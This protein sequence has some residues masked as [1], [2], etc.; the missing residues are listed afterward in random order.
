SS[1][2]APY[3]SRY[4]SNSHTI[5]RSTAVV[6]GVV[7]AR[8]F[9]QG[10][11]IMIGS[12][13]FTTNTP[14]DRVIANAMLW[15]QQAAPGPVAM[16][17]TISGSFTNGVWAGP[18]TIHDLQTNI[19]MRASIASAEGFSNP[20]NTAV[21]NDLVL[22]VSN[23]PDPVGVGF[24]VNYTV[25]A[26]NTGPDESTQVIITNLL[27]PGAVF[28]SAIL[29]QGSFTNNEGT[30][31]C[32]LGSVAAGADATVTLT[33]NHPAA[34]VF[35]NRA[36]ISRL[37]PESYLLN[38]SAEAITTVTPPAISITDVTITEGD[39]GSTNAIFDIRLSVP[40]PQ[41]VSVN[42]ATANGTALAGLDYIA[43]S[44]TVIFAPGETNKP[45]SI[46]VL[47]DLLDEPNESY[48]VNLSSPTNATLADNQ[49][50]GTIIDN[51]PAPAMAI[52]DTSVV[53]G[54][55]GTTNAAFL[56]TLSSPSGF[57]VSASYSTSNGTAVSSSDY[58]AISG[59]VSFAAGET[60]KIILVQVRGDLTNELDEVF[61]VNLSNPQNATFAKSSAACTIINDDLNPTI[62]LS[63]AVLIQEACSPTNGVIDPGE[64]VTVNF[65]LTNAGT[66]IAASNLTATL[67]STNG[68]V[69]STL[70]Q[71]F[72][73]I[74]I[75][76][77]ATRPFS[78]AV[79]GACGTSFNAVLQ[80]QSGSNV[81]GVVTQHFQLGGLGVLFSQ[82]FDSVVAPSIPTGWSTFLSGGT[83]AWHTSTNARDT[84]P[85]AVFTPNPSTTSDNQLTSPAIIIPSTNAQLSFRH[86]Y[87][88]ESCCDYCF[89]EISINNGAFTNITTA[90]GSFIT[91]GYNNG[92][93]WSGSSAGFVTSTVRFPASAA[94]QSVRLRWR[95]TSDS[96]VS[97]MGWYVDTISISD[98]I[99]CCLT[100]DI[101][102]SVNAAPNP[103]PIHANLTYTL[104]VTNT[105]PTLATGVMVTNWLPANFNITSVFP[106]QGTV[107]N[108]G[109]HLVFNLGTIAGG[110]HAIM[111]LNGIPTSTGVITNTASV[112]RAE[113]DPD[114]GNNTASAVTTVFLPSLTISDRTITEGHNGTT[115]ALVS[116]SLTP[117]SSQTVQVNFATLNGSAV[118][119]SDYTATNGV[120]VFAPGETNKNI[121]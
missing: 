4:T 67:L 16:S 108:M 115:Q 56:V 93:R 113:S 28:V 25:R 43:S 66:G 88:T 84:F 14:M 117:A 20:F 119:P 2:T 9:G 51:D 52:S 121:A 61:Y 42:F 100:D 116:V 50:L 87:S 112:Y 57:N 41:V 36:F 5:I 29:S 37:E 39:V 11:A 80:L 102:I 55:S 54:N 6:A 8:E 82:N 105:G 26:E 34:G 90:G 60:N 73:T 44:G 75:G 53:E 3:T 96:S 110:A 59:A 111:T 13:F 19:Q 15:A 12:D 40:S 69:P 62:L 71:N 103:V 70:Q 86:N 92:T 118:A 33:V 74:P 91:G 78:F 1:F 68:V 24:N 98:N 22:T 76:N 47:G 21:I 64:S 120:L 72:G 83:T 58:I 63:S 65:T 10:R 89:L 79:L 49:G 45:V 114:P 109:T 17:P 31:I 77:S 94:G 48:Y 81:I 97:G 23:T 32:E 35:T 101:S 30:I 104:A 27:P 107:T 7:Q 95:F 18:V 99:N 46:E 106:S 85:N 38:N